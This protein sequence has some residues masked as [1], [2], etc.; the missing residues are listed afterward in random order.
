MKDRTHHGRERVS[1]RFLRR[2]LMGERMNLSAYMWAA[3]RLSGL[4]LLFYLGLHIYTLASVRKGADYFDRIMRQMESGEIKIL[5]VAIIGIA[6]F[7]AC[8]GLRLVLTN[9][10]VDLDQKVLAYGT[11]AATILFII[12]SVRAVF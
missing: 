8:N 4:A 9:L 7:H 6:F 3:Q 10:F 5:E 1:A 2:T 12:L 11:A